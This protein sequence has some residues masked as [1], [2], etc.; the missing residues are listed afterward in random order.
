M[1]FVIYKYKRNTF[2][3]MKVKLFKKRGQYIQ[4]EIWQG[5]KK[6]NSGWYKCCCNQTKGDIAKEIENMYSNIN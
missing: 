4:Y 1:V 6:L 5:K 2:T 3:V